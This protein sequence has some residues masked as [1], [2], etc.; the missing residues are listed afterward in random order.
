METETVLVGDVDRK[1]REG[2][3]LHGPPILDD[4]KQWRQTIIQRYPDAYTTALM[5]STKKTK[6]LVDIEW[7]FQKIADLFAR[8]LDETLHDQHQDE[9]EEDGDPVEPLLS[10]VGWPSFIPKFGLKDLGVL[11]IA[12]V[13]IFVVNPIMYA[14]GVGASLGQ[15]THAKMTFAVQF[16]L[17]AF[18]VFLKLSYLH[19]RDLQG[20]QIAKIDV[21]GIP[22]TGLKFKYADMILNRVENMAKINGLV[23]DGDIPGEVRDKVRQLFESI[24]GDNHTNLTH[25]LWILLQY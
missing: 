14:I 1:M 12:F 4:T 13:S 21:K 7:L 25:A 8:S 23:F 19:V 10:N 24:L 18:R 16:I 3:K 9:G 2:W 6:S 15:A 17:L 5:I 20:L 22:F 11:S